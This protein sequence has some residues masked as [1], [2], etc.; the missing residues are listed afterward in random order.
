MLPGC[1]FEKIPTPANFKHHFPLTESV[2]G[3]L[4]L[5]ICAALGKRNLNFPF[6][7][8][9]DLRF[10]SKAVLKPLCGHRSQGVAPLPLRSGLRDAS[11]WS[12]DLPGATEKK[13]ASPH[14]P[15]KDSAEKTLW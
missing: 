5:E 1:C 13:K 11:L 15:R 4:V 2:W 12:W 6:R 10:L 14:R 9:L 3:R 8:L 7:F